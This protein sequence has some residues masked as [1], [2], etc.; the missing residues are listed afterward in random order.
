MGS[1]AI[2]YSFFFSSRRRH[3]RFDC[4]W[5]SDVCSSRSHI[6]S[7]E[8]QIFGLM[9]G[10]YRVRLLQ[11]L[12]VDERPVSRR[13]KLVGFGR[14]NPPRKRNAKHRSEA[15]ACEYEH[16]VRGLKDF[17]LQGIKKTVAA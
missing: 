5:S 11:Q 9:C 2:V 13:R 16:E 1:R 15:D 12:E 7:N 4:D 8:A 3:T 14:L 17:E 10:T 6:A